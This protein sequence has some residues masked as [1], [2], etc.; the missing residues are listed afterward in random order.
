MVS[1]AQTRVAPVKGNDNSATD[2]NDNIK[3]ELAQ[4][5]AEYA[6][7]N[8]NAAFPV[9]YRYRQSPLFSAANQKSLG[10]MYSEGKGVTQNYS[11]A[12]HWYQKAAEQGNEDAQKA[13]IRLGINYKK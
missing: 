6:N 10:Y 1:Y 3:K 8:Y 7:E 4:A 2:I 9:F 13:C 12:A 5:E 11:Q